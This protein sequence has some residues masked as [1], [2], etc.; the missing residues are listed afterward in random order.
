MIDPIT[1]E[2]LR[3]RL[4]TV[5]DEGAAVLRNVSGSPSVAQ[6]NDCNVAL[7]TAEG[8]GVIIGRGIASHAMSCIQTAKYVLKHHSENPGIGPDD[9]FFSNHPYIGTPHQTCG[10]MVAP[11]FAGNRLIA[12][13]GAGVHF[14]DVGGCEPGQVSIGARSIWDEAIPVP[15]IKLVEGG[16]LRKDLEEDFLVR[17]RTRVQNAVDLKSMIGAHHAIVGRIMGMV[18][19]YG[20]ETVV[21]AL[22]RVIGISEAKLRS[23]L[24]EIPDGAWSCDNYLDYYDEKRMKVYACRLTLKKQGEGLVFDFT[25]S[26]P[27]ARAVVNATFGATEG[28]ILRA[29]LGIF[30]F[31]VAHCP[32]ALQRIMRIDATEGTIVHCAW[33]AGVCKGTTSV[34][35]SVW[36]VATHCLSQMLLSSEKYAPRATAVSRGHLILTDI[37]GKDQ[38]GSLFAAVIQE[39]GLAAGSGAGVSTDGIDT[40]GVTEPEV[41]IPNVENNEFRYPLL[42]LYRRQRTD[43]EGPGKQRGGVGLSMAYMPHD[44]AGIPDVMIHTHGVTFPSAHGLS[45][46]YPAAINRLT[47]KRGTN[48]AELFQRGILPGEMAEIDARSEET[49]APFAH[50]RLAKGDIFEVSGGGGGGYGDPLDRAPERVADDVARGLVSRESAAARYGVVLN[51]TRAD[52]TA[53][54]AKRAATKAERKSSAAKPRCAPLSANGAAGPLVAGINEYL[55]IVQAPAG[56]VVRCRCGCI[57]LQAAE[58]YHQCLAVRETAGQTHPLGRDRETPGFTVREF[59]CPNCWTVVDIA[60]VMAETEV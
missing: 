21:E 27:Q 44:V 10:V 53:T 1:F 54:A 12:W 37:L 2:V 55:S 38:Y 35:Q 25:K 59:F 51:G 15:P 46:G 43:S 49:P 22:D 11:I 40:G 29:M 48:I 20:T 19:R 16:R 8:E 34:T 32:A 57:L 6:S 5:V 17:S 41:A 26:S 23:I 47:I 52:A 42:Y 9:M 24:R 30:G 60:V 14:G 39:C 33:P 50:D 45:G 28:Y 58:D 31:A 18:P 56:A 36:Q 13:S 7:L 4:A 3:H